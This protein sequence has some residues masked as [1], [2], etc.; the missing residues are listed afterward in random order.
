MRAVF[1][2]LLG[3][4]LW[5]SPLTI[6]SIP[7]LTTLRFRRLDFTNRVSEPLGCISSEY[8]RT[9]QHLLQLCDPLSSFRSVSS[10]RR[11]LLEGYET[12]GSLAAS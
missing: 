9:E 12:L 6:L 1:L 11:L 3:R 7:Y 5:R 10:V 2:K 8:Y 4:G